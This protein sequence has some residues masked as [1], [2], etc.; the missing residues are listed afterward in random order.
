MP[1][2]SA[3]RRRARSAA[4]APAASSPFAKCAAARSPHASA[5]AC[6]V[7]TYSDSDA[8]ASAARPSLVAASPP[9]RRSAR[10]RAS[11]TRGHANA[12]IP[13]STTIDAAPMAILRVHRR[14]ARVSIEMTRGSTRLHD[15]QDRWSIA[16]NVVQVHSRS[17]GSLQ[18]GHARTPGPTSVPQTMQRSVRSIEAGGYGGGARPVTTPCDAT[19]ASWRPA[20]SL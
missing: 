14:R 12:P 20:Q 9:D 4:S 7:R 13:P 8:T 3:S 5:S 6:R 2:D 17:R 15:G 10:R 11:R 16:T 1:G 18:R 19:G